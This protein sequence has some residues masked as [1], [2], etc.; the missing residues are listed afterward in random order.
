MLYTQPNRVTVDGAGRREDVAN[1][2]T[3]VDNTTGEHIQDPRLILQ[4]F[5]ALCFYLSWVESFAHPSSDDSIISMFKSLRVSH[6][7][8]MAARSNVEELLKIKAEESAQRASTGQ[9]FKSAVTDKMAEEALAAKKGADASYMGTNV[10]IAKQVAK[11]LDIGWDKCKSLQDLTSESTDL[12]QNGW[13]DKMLPHQNLIKA[14]GHEGEPFGPDAAGRW[15]LRY[16]VNQMPGLGHNQLVPVAG[17]PLADNVAA[18]VH[19]TDYPDDANDTWRSSL[20]YQN[21]P[22]PLGITGVNTREFRKAWKNTNLS[23]DGIK[24]KKN[25]VARVGHM[26]LMSRIMDLHLTFCQSCEAGRNYFL[27]MHEWSLLQTRRTGIPEDP[28]ASVLNFD[29]PGHEITSNSH[30]QQRIYSLLFLA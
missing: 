22:D 7:A 13:H 26:Q 10:R 3:V 20:I 25:H 19:Y 27:K 23:F 16:T 11:L 5:V 30:R 24:T 28:R 21:M 12:N 15:N 18:P 1:P 9:N 17:G 6:E 14:V 4:N 29:D 8:A 2:I